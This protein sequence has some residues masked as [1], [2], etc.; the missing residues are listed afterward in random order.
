MTGGGLVRHRAP[1]QSRAVRIFNGTLTGIGE[2]LITAGLVVA[3]FLCWQLWWTGIDANASARAVAT[4]FHEKQVES[5]QKA[6]TKHTDAPPVME[7]VGYGETIGML[8]VPKWYGVTNNNMPIME[9]T[10]SDVLDQAA[11]GH[12]TNTQQ[13]GELGNFA[14]AGHRRTYGNSFRRIDLLQEGDE[15]DRRRVRKRP[16]LDRPRA[17]QVLDGSLRGTS[18]VRAQRSGGQL[19]YGFIWRHLPGP[20][21]LKAI[22]SLV[23]IAGV[24]YVLMQYVFPWANATWHLSGNADVG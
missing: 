1:G 4:Q 16:A 3:L 12:Y 19:M 6:G 20:A 2:L 21:W 8:V 15:I 18:G 17:V 13:L 23:L 5:P 14:I 7:Q 24:V 22:E 10:G 9:G 11:A